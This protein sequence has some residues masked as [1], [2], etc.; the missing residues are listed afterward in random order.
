MGLLPWKLSRRELK[1]CDPP[2]GSCLHGNTKGSPRGA[3]G[4]FGDRSCIDDESGEAWILSDFDGVPVAS[5][6][7]RIE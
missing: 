7:W 2:S 6:S 3:L 1:A 5:L 4:G